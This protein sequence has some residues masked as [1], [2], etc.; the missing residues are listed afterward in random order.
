MNQS[1]QEF[2][3]GEVS[4]YET[5][6]RT[7]GY[8]PPIW[9][10]P[11][12]SCA[13]LQK[14]C[15][16]SSPNPLAFEFGSG[17]STIA[18]RSICQGVTSVENSSEWLEKTEVLPG[19]ISKR[20]SDVTAVVPLSL[21]RIGI[22]PYQS[23]QLDDRPDLTRL[24][25]TADLILVDSPPNPATREH[26]LV[27][28]LQHAKIGALIVLDDLDVPAT[29]RFAE[30]LS[31]DNA[32]TLDFFAVPIDHVLGIFQKNAAVPIKHRPR[33]REIIGAWRRR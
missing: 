14:L 26:A 33:A 19:Q 27:T 22:V 11:E 30:R 31:R 24:L 12:T 1:L 6:V 23:F 5:M 32:G 7:T 17:R 10:L 2:L 15:G 25:A 9:I 3:A 18:L 21:C 13:L 29:S 4:A 8:R 16:R 28:A 20:L